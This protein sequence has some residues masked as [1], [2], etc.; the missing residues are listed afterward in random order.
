M[1]KTKVIILTVF[2][3]LG[4]T[5]KGIYP[6]IVEHESVVRINEIFYHNEIDTVMIG[7]ALPVKYG[8]VG[9][10]KVSFKKIDGT[11]IRFVDTAAD[12]NEG[13]FKYVD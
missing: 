2:L 5:K 13:S 1:E 6:I 11:L 4:C 3:L 7:N 8:I 10:Q 9:V 12:P